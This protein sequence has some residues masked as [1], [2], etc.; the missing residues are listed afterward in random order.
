ME[1]KRLYRRLFRSGENYQ[2]VLSEAHKTFCSTPSQNLLE[3]LKHAKRGVCADV[4][5]S[6]SENE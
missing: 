5:Q 3:F 6:T 2:K 4:G 1:L